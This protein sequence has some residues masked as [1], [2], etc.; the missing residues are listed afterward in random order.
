LSNQQIDRW[1]ITIF[2]KQALLTIRLLAVSCDAGDTSDEANICERLLRLGCAEIPASPEVAKV[3][4][5]AILPDATCE[6]LALWAFLSQGE[7]EHRE[8]WKGVL[9]LMPIDIA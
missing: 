7:G 8:Q 6:Q 9:P 4:P 1:L 2:A 5:G 3:L